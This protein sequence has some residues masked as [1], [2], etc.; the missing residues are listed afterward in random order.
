MQEGASHWIDAHC[1][2]ADPRLDGRREEVLERALRAGV[3]GFVFSGVDPE[4][5]ARQ[6]QIAAAWH[7]RARFALGGGLHPWFVARSSADV[8]ERAWA[9]LQAWVEAEGGAGPHS[10]GETGLDWSPRCAPESREAQAHWF[11]AHIRLARQARLPLVLHV[12]RAHP[13]ALRLLGEEVSQGGPLLQGGLVHAFYVSSR[14]SSEIDRIIRGYLDLGFCLSLGGAMSPAP[15]RQGKGFEKFKQA[16]LKIPGERLLVE[17]DAPDQ[18]PHGFTGDFLGVQSGQGLSPG[19]D[20]WP[21]QG[22]GEHLGK[23]LGDD[24]EPS[25]LP[26]LAEIL[27]SW[28]GESARTVLDRSALQIRKLFQI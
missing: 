10:I 27:G 15:D 6:R 25:V 13:E 5:W 7:P 9:E 1:H 17:S 14:Q 12:V 3:D 26:F 18:K 4:D 24:N 8:L 11:R 20:K 2:L 19:L 16:V 22:L 23:Y 28:R 21:G